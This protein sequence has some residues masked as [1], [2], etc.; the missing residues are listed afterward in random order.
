MVTIQGA[1]SIGRAETNQVVLADG[2]ASRKHAVIHRQGKASIGWSIS[3]AAMA[4]IS[5][6]AGFPNPSP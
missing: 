2:K 1:C 6:V 5:T 4:P 3:G